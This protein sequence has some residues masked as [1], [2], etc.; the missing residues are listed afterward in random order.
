MFFAA[1]RMAR[2]RKRSQSNPTEEMLQWTEDND[3]SVGTPPSLKAAPRRSIDGVYPS[4]SQM[5]LT[6]IVGIA[7]PEYQPPE[8][9]SA[10]RPRSS[11]DTLPIGG[12]VCPIGSPSVVKSLVN[13]PIPPQKYDTLED[14]IKSFPELQ[15]I[16]A[17]QE[18]RIQ[19][20]KIPM[21][22]VHRYEKPKPVEPVKSSLPDPST[23]RFFSTL[24]SAA[25]SSV[26]P[27]ATESKTV[28]PPSEPTEAAGGGLLAGIDDL[29][30][31]S[32]KSKLKSRRR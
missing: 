32:K 22:F 25:S 31:G 21:E 27:S 14:L 16:I 15:T 29:F 9:R 1:E 6:D 17:I 23:T 18:S 19:H 12:M 11:A 5:T 28:T 8:K 20:S 24:P 26:F 7:E 4:F 2:G 3:V 13:Q 30:G 10:K